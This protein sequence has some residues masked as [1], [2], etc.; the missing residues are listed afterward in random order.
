MAKKYCC[1]EILYLEKQEQAMSNEIIKVISYNCNSLRKNVDT[2]RK[3]LDGCDVL[4][5]QEIM[6]VEEDIGIISQI[7]EE[8]IFVATPS[9]K[10]N[11]NSFD[12]RPSGGNAII[13]SKSLDI[14]IEF[15]A[16]SEHYLLSELTV[17]WK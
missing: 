12:W 10:A 11:S 4:L 5:L 14:V 13:W 3:L 6:L 9:R 17:K 16:S 15:K 7:N 8:I 2:V 1:K